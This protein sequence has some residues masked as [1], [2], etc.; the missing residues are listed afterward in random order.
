MELI[1]WNDGTAEQVSHKVAE[2]V[3]A[4][5][6]AI[7]RMQTA[8]KAVEEWWLT[9]EMHKHNGAPACIFAVREALKQSARK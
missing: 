5:G 7:E 8:L 4:Q 1:D 3:M 2:F 6:R 9:Q